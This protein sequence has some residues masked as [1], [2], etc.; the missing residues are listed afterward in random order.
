MAGSIQ[1]S[2]R[3]FHE[4]HLQEYGYEDDE[5]EGEFQQ[6]GPGGSEVEEL[7]QIFR[8]LEL[9]ISRLEY[10][11]VGVMW[12]N[13]VWCCLLCMICAASCTMNDCFFAALK[14]FILLQYVVVWNARSLELQ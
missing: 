13:V 5:D 12:C 6:Q 3:S 4:D 10:Q 1:G 11:R 9:K 2:H 7:A 14:V 8:D